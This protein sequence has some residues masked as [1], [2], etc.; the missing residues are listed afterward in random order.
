MIDCGVKCTKDAPQNIG[1][2]T[3]LQEVKVYT[4]LIGKTFTNV[5]VT[6]DMEQMRFEN[7]E[8]CYMFYHDLDYSET[9]EI[10]Q[11]DGNL[12]DLIGSPIKMAESVETKVQESGFA[13]GSETHTFY[14]FATSK[15]YVTV[16]WVG[17]SN[18]YYSE[19]VD[20]KRL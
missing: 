13:W 9:V 6:Q 20:F 19:S 8:E 4:D 3:M 2:E 14:R 15:G 12:S 7:A 10:S 17:E 11:I 5:W 18:G 16:R 1:G